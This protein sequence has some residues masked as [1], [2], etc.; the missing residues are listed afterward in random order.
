M[1][2]SKQEGAAAT[3]QQLGSMS[4]GDDSVAR[5]DNNNE[6]AARR[7]KCDHPDQ[8]ILID[9]PS[10]RLSREVFHLDTIS[11]SW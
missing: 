3:A 8:E 9:S 11:L 7:E 10:Q 2:S 1:A 5:K 4:L 6:P